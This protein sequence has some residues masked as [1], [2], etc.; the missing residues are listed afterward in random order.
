MYCCVCGR[1]I[2]G[3]HIVLQ[4]TVVSRSVCLACAIKVYDQLVELKR[5]LGKKERE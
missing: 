3:N 2:K 5:Q 1:E 4:L